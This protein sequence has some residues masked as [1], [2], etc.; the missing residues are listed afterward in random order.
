[1]NL[2]V[3][4]LLNRV[5]D[6]DDLTQKEQ[7]KLVAFFHCVEHN[8]ERF[9]Q[10]D[11]KDEF[12]KQ[13]LLQ[14]SN[15]SREFSKL[16]KLKPPIVVSNGNGIAFHRTAKKNLEESFLGLKHRQDVS[17]VLRDLLDK[18]SGNEQKLFLEE[19]ISCFEIKSYRA[20]IILTWLLTVDT[21]YEFILRSKNLN[22]FNAAIQKHGKYKKITVT[23]K[24]DFNE[25]KET[26]FIELM[27]VGKLISNDRRKIL[28]EKLGIRNSCAHPNSV[29]FK[30]YKAISFIQDLVSNI[31]TYYQ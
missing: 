13:K 29:L 16:S 21:L 5:S 6:F 7:V 15:L 20:A 28:D 2:T 18:I 11:I 30:E 12:D 14:P 27:R 10:S 4:E 31:I 22:K 19:A 3:N 17:I 1:M 8:K 26:D 23:K 25:I 9:T 24:E